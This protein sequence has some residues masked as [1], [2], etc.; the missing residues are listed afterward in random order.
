MKKILYALAI[1]GLLV[2]CGEDELTNSID[3]SSPYVITDNPSDPIQHRCYEIYQKYG[4]SVF[5]NDTIQTTLTGSDHKGNPIYQYETLDLNWDFTSHDGRTVTYKYDYLTR[6]ED[7]ENALR[8]VD[9]YLSVASK[10]MRP[11]SILLTDTIRKVTSSEVNVKNVYLSNFR[12]L[13]MA[14]LRSYTDTQ[15]DSLSHAIIR[16]TV[17]EKIKLNTT[18]TARFWE[19]SSKSN[20]YGLTWIGSEGLGVTSE[21]FQDGNKNPGL[22]P[23]HIWDDDAYENSCESYQLSKYNVQYGGWTEEKF[24]A[25]REEIISTIGQ[26]G[27]ISGA[28]DVTSGSTTAAMGHLKSPSKSEDLNFYIETILELSESE[29]KA[30]YGGSSLVMKKYNI[31]ATYITETLEIDLN[32]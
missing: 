25:A 27:F 11:F 16:N 4:V 7:K 26:F 5:F 31:L 20:W 30:R 10:S 15:I 17:T 21:Y 19:I 14:R 23:N 18:L 13:A 3:F 2:G 32:K 8:F 29:F 1:C 28:D 9:S 12:L 24:E 6:Q 22:S